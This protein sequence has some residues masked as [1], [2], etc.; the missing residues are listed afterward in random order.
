MKNCNGIH[1]LTQLD[2]CRP[3]HS[4]SCR[5]NSFTILQCRIP[6]SMNIARHRGI[7]H[8]HKTN[9][10]SLGRQRH[11]CVNLARLAPT[12]PPESRPF[13]DVPPI[14]TLDARGADYQGTVIPG[15]HVGALRVESIPLQLFG[16]RLP[17]DKD[18]LLR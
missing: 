15:Q 5:I 10:V 9:R 11:A 13:A 16:H 6:A 1:Q 8:V 2:T 14:I 3:T 18:G 17:S 4:D 7:P 12:M